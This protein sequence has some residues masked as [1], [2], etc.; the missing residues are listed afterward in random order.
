MRNELNRFS[1]SIRNTDKNFSFAD[2]IS[3]TVM[4]RLGIRLA[5]TFDRDFAQYGL[6]ALP[7]QRG[8]V[9]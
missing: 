5:F 8:G 7:Q 4:E 2:A 6:T 9:T 3:F 1:F